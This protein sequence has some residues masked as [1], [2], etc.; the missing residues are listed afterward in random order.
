[1]ACSCGAQDDRYLPHP[2]H[3]W[4][5][6]DFLENHVTLVVFIKIKNKNKL[7]ALE[8]FFFSFKLNLS[9]VMHFGKSG[10]RCKSLQCW[11]MS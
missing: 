7:D 4:T 1:M 6:M 3:V 10:R 2:L 11:M 5:C 8:L 9:R